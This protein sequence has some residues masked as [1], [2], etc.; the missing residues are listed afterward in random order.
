MIKAMVVTR[1]QDMS[2]PEV[3]QE[4][5]QETIASSS[6]AL[7]CT[8]FGLLMV[9]L[10]TVSMMAMWGA[11]LARGAACPSSALAG[12]CITFT[13]TRLPCLQGGQ[14]GQQ[15]TE[16]MHSSSNNVPN[17]AAVAQ[18]LVKTWFGEDMSW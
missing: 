18:A 12:S 9:L 15:Q 3:P 8:R 5:V 6:H 13:A 16:K 2:C 1:K 17:H 11:L 14:Q 7:T 10:T 4:P